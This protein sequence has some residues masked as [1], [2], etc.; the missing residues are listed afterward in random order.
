MVKK[1]SGSFARPQ[2][3]LNPNNP[4]RMCLLVFEESS[5]L[6]G[7]D[8]SAHLDPGQA[9]HALDRALCAVAAWKDCLQGSIGAVLFRFCS[10]KN[11]ER[12]SQRDWNI[13][14]SAVGNKT[15]CLGKI[16]QVV[17]LGMF[18]D[19][20]KPGLDWFCLVAS[21]T[22]TTY[23][24]LRHDPRPSNP[25]ANALVAPHVLPED[26][27]ATAAE[28]VGWS[29]GYP[30]NLP[31]NQGRM[32]GAEVFLEASKIQQWRGQDDLNLSEICNL[33]ASRIIRIIRIQVCGWTSTLQNSNPDTPWKP[34][35][36]PKSCRTASL[37]RTAA[38]EAWSTGRCSC[39]PV[40]DH[41]ISRLN[42]LATGMS[43]KNWGHGR[44]TKH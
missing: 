33:A 12:H 24:I 2:C 8:W 5:V 31:T 19:V 28:T 38:Y 22:R 37:D 36:N 29:G 34:R 13:T 3:Q 42:E 6:R 18:H 30:E 26:K 44:S 25:A 27:S 14:V 9:C 16:Q 21:H 41:V 20:S 23:A 39:V 7:C 15:V 35:R 4:F 32:S 11:E 40:G 43:D 1:N 17:Y 10:A